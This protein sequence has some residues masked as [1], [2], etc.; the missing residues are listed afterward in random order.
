MHLC[1]YRTQAPMRGCHW[2][3][4]VYIFQTLCLCNKLT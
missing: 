3:L 4:V 1:A 2:L